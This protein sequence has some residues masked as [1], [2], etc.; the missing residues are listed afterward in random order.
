MCDWHK[1]SELRESINSIKWETGTLTSYIRDTS[2]ISKLE[3]MLYMLPPVCLNTPNKSLSKQYTLNKWWISFTVIDYSN[4]LVVKRC[5]W[6]TYFGVN[7]Q[8]LTWYLSAFFSNILI[9]IFYVCICIEESA[10]NIYFF[11]QQMIDFP[12]TKKNKAS[13]V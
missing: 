4:I 1:K 2:A 10:E 6:L 3:D 5:P 12:V 13:K 7:S 8:T 11:L 9:I